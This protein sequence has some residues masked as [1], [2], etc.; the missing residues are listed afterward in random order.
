ME[1]LWGA[2]NLTG[3]NVE[4]YLPLDDI[5]LTETHLSL[6][7]RVMYDRNVESVMLYLTPYARSYIFCPRI[8]KTR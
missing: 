2:D 6:V 1:P 3:T 5:D 4:W 8:Q 7:C